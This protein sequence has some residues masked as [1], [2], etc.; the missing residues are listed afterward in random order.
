MNSVLLLDSLRSN[1]RS[2]T[3]WS[4]V[5]S[6]RT[7]FLNNISTLCTGY[8]WIDWSDCCRDVLAARV[9]FFLESLLINCS[10]HVWWIINY[11]FTLAKRC[12]QPLSQWYMLLHFRLEQVPTDW[13]I[14][15]RYITWNDILMQSTDRDA[16]ESSY[17]ESSR[18]ATVTI[19]GWWDTVHGHTQQE[20]TKN[21]LIWLLAHFISFLWRST[22][23]ERS[24]LSMLLGWNFV[25]ALWYARSQRKYLKNKYLIIL[26]LTSKCNQ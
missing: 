20:G 1:A 22:T 8:G 13:T 19:L 9:E 16:G 17:I 14:K 11:D 2:W 6:S 12:Y 3:L 23:Y 10:T 24:S 21:E 18:D 26:K 7:F 25:G 4:A 15:M 5:R